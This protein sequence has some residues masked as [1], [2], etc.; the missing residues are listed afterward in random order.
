MLFDFLVNLWLSKS[1]LI[2][3][4][5]S[6]SSVSNYINKDVFLEFLEKNQENGENGGDYKVDEWQAGGAAF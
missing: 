3:L 5:V 1:W 6:I 2:L 4:V